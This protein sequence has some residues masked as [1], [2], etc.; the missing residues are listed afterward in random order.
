MITF[1]AKMLELLFFSCENDDDNLVLIGM[2]RKHNIDGA[3][4]N[5]YW[6]GLESEPQWNLVGRRHGPLWPPGAS[7]HVDNMP[8]LILTLSYIKL[9]DSYLR[10]SRCFN[11]DHFRPCFFF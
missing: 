2:T 6:I 8:N 3:I 1:D 9:T 5:S 11:F 7:H 4:H 10:R